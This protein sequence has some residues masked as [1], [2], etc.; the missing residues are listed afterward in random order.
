MRPLALVLLVL[1]P[2][3]AASTCHVEDAVTTCH[4]TTAAELEVA[5]ADPLTHVV[6]LTVPE[7]A[8]DRTL[9]LDH[10]VSIVGAPTRLVGPRNASIADLERRGLEIKLPGCVEGG[11]TRNPVV[12]SVEVGGHT[13]ETCPYAYFAVSYTHLTLPTICSV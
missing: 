4:V 10:D 1:A 9:V 8:L 7:I 13:C 12:F 2:A 5:V 6:R 3:D 11:N